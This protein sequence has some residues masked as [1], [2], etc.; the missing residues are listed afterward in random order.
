[1]TKQ[2]FFVAGIVCLML[3]FGSCSKSATSYFPL[4]QGRVWTYQISM[5]MPFGGERNVTMTLTNLAPRQLDGKTVTPQKMELQFQ[6]ESK[7]SFMYFAEGPGGV[8]NVADQDS[9]DVKPII[10]NPPSY[11]LKK[12]IKTGTAWA[13]TLNPANTHSGPAK[14]TIE[15]TDETVDVP[16]GTFKQCVMIHIAGNSKQSAG[17]DEY[18]WFAPSV[19][20][21]KVIDK[22]AGPFSSMVLKSFKK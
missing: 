14:A 20:M 18:Q 4:D 19:G 10:V 13:T 21:I 17:Q 7:Y 9:G 5:K 6:G 3:G 1:M 8:V 11:V 22:G 12:P 16:A 2:C 15:S